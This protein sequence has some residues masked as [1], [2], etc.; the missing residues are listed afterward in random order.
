MVGTISNIYLLIFL[1]LI[2]SLCCQILSGKKPTFFFALFTSILLFILSLKIFPQILSNE[3][4]SNDFQISLVS[5]GI[6]FKLDIVGATFLVLLLFLKIIT[7]FFFRSDIE[8][9]LDAKSS[10][11]FYSVFLL[12]LF[13]LIGI[14]TSNNLFN[15]FFFFEIYAFSFFAITSISADLKLLK[16]SF[17]YF[18]LSAASSLIIIF[19]F[20]G[21]YLVFGEVNFDK[22][23]E[24]FYLLPPEN[25]W[26]VQVIFALLAIA[27]F[28]RFFPLWLYFKKLRSSSVITSFLIHDSLFI[29]T[30]VGIFLLLKFVYF[31]F[32]NNLLL[33]SLNLDIILVLAA[34]SLIFYSTL[35]LYR[36]KHL[37]LICLYFCLNNLGFILASI[38]LQT[39]ESMQALFFYVLNF[40]LVNFFI[41]IF[42]S[43][44]KRYFHTSS[45][46]KIWLVRRNHLML[47][48]PI[49]LIVFFIIV[50]PI[51]FMFLG[52]WYLA[53]TSLKPG[54]ELSLLG[55][56]IASNFVYIAVAIR[57]IDAF[58]SPNKANEMP[59][60]AAKNY[61]SYLL[62]FW[63]LIIAIFASIALSDHLNSLSGRFATYLYSSTI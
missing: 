55:A 23:A 36:Q 20:L 12:N 56:I 1:P 43:F 48:L 38:A 6:E 16:L 32:G 5:I 25:I 13:A 17:R 24:N 37:K 51:S 22:M 31:F 47:T 46:S 52:N 29:K 45:M 63:L 57:L 49:K 8:K 62:C 9:F 4:I 15:L 39:V 19:C 42:A 10:R 41:F 3:K 27:I 54:F 61:Y 26:F 30:L 35:N 58:F 7:L 18:C 59:V 33:R 34:I 40:A 60:L 28:I 53:Y 14:F 21:I 11:A 44:L 2:A 50:L